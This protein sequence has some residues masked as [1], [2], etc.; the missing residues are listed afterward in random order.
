MFAF[1]ELIDA[2]KRDDWREYFIELMNIPDYL[3]FVAHIIFF[4]LVI[5]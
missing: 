3:G 1:L 5:V 2:I 4:F